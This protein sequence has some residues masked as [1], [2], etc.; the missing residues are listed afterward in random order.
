MKKVYLDIILAGVIS[1]LT[2]TSSP[3]VAADSVVVIPLGGNKYYMYWQ[4]EWATDKA[5]KVGDGVQIN[6]NSYMCIAAH[7]SVAPPDKEYWALLA[8]AGKDGADGAPGKDGVDG[9]PGKDGADGAPGT[10]GID[11]VDGAPGTNG[12]DGVNGI[13]G[14]PG[15]I[16]PPGPAGTGPVNTSCP[17]GRYVTGFDANGNIICSKN[18]AIV[19]ITS[20]TYNG[21]L[22]GISGADSKCMAR[23]AAGSLP[24]YYK[25][26]LSSDSTHSPS[27]GFIQNPE[28]YIL[29]DRSTLVADSWNDL[30]SPDSDGNFLLNAINRNEYGQIQEGKAWTSTYPTGIPCDDIAEDSCL[31]WTFSGSAMKGDAGSTESTDFQWSYLPVEGELTCD[32]QARIYCFQQ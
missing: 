29:A 8:A 21:N 25:A 22:G 4:G 31:G 2:V 6:G 32:A 14:A 15:E 20:T 23:A 24:G 9:A 26:W 1:T 19:F 30:T 13:D 10:N 11:G 3:A 5:Y 27:T 12:I 7:S 28:G 17:T 16:G 18:P